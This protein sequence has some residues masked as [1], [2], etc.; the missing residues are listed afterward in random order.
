MK[1]PLIGVEMKNGHVLRLVLAGLLASLLCSVN[2]Q[3]HASFGGPNCFNGGGQD[4]DHT[5][6][7]EIDASNI[8][9]PLLLKIQSITIKPSNV[10]ITQKPTQIQI[11]WVISVSPSSDWTNAGI[12]GFYVHDESSSGVDAF[13]ATGCTLKGI[14]S[15]IVSPHDSIQ[16]GAD[17]YQFTENFIVPPTCSTGK[18]SIATDINQPNPQG[19]VAQNCDSCGTED[20]GIL[21][22]LELPTNKFSVSNNL[23]SKQRVAASTAATVSTPPS[24]SSHAPSKTKV[25]QPASKSGKTSRGPQ[26]CSASVEQQLLNIVKYIQINA[27]EDQLYQGEMQQ[28]QQNIGQDNAT[29]NYLGAATDRQAV[30]GYQAKINANNAEDSIKRQQFATLTANCV[31][32]L[33][34]TP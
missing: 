30:M 22:A 1:A 14:D 16:A 24:V 21:P 29:G 4:A 5:M 12:T 18:Y 33:V 31:N 34:P 23:T 17:L 9:H 2:N 6:Y 27:S 20:A 25:S 19:N 10:I 13:D 32:T 26:P 8:C 11:S 15:S 7:G 3:A 28:A